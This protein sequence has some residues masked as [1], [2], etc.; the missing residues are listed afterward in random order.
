VPRQSYVCGITLWILSVL[1]ICLGSDARAQCPDSME[2]WHRQWRSGSIER[3]VLAAMI[4]C[5]E[6]HRRTPAP[7]LDYWIATSMIQ[8]DSLRSDAEPYFN[9]LLTLDYLDKD[10]QDAVTISRRS[11]EHGGRA[12]D[13]VFV[14]SNTFKSGAKRRR[15]VFMLASATDAA[16]LSDSRKHT[17]GK[18]VSPGKRETPSGI[19]QLDWTGK[20]PAWTAGIEA[21][22]DQLQGLVP[23]TNM[24][25]Q[26][27]GS[28]RGFPQ[29]DWKGKY[30][31]LP[32][33][34]DALMK[35]YRGLAYDKYLN[36]S[37]MSK[38]SVKTREKNK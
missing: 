13:L 29:L 18:L 34:Y 36:S 2:I 6:S 28:T 25:P 8:F 33:G 4:R 19:P 3:S 14:K 9:S 23:D 12:A 21:K 32:A 15:P 30:P 24:S 22:M 38:D 20:Y 35:R 27:N 10:A 7:Q 37:K 1:G 11:C 17:P 31:E 5:R 16:P 26:K